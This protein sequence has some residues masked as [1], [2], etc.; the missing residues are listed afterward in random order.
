MA[1]YLTV[2]A[3]K[4]QAKGVPSVQSRVVNLQ[5]LC[6]AITVESLSAAL[7]QAFEETYGLTAQ[8]LS[9]ES[10][11]WE[12][13]RK[14]S[15]S[16]ASWQ[17]RLGREMPF[18]CELAER[19]SWGEVVFRF[20]V[21]KGKITDVQVYSDAMDTDFIEKVPPLLRNLPFSFSVLADALN[22][23]AQTPQYVT[24]TTDLQTLLRNGP[25]QAKGGKAK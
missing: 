12:E 25:R 3:K 14:I 17:W 11:D 24:M 16:F 15:A 9:A 6:P 7:F 21:N 4:L 22:P 2:S 13:V 1:R 8:I 10:V 18:S 23:L 19:F 20:D 5:A